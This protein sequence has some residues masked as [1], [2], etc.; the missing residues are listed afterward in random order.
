MQLLAAEDLSPPSLGQSADTLTLPLNQLAAAAKDRDTADTPHVCAD[1][2]SGDREPERKGPEGTARANGRVSLHCLQQ[3][4]AAELAGRSAID[5]CGPE[6]AAGACDPQVRTAGKGAVLSAGSL[7]GATAAGWEG[8][9]RAS[10]EASAGFHG[11]P[12]ASGAPRG[13]G[14]PP[15][16]ALNPRPSSPSPSPAAAAGAP[17]QRCAAA[18]SRLR[19][20]AGQVGP[21]LAVT[22]AGAPPNGGPAQEGFATGNPVLACVRMWLLHDL[23]ASK[24]YLRGSM[25]TQARISRMVL[26]PAFHKKLL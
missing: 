17:A 12:R 19:W 11:A 10:C 8:W 6:L 14:T 15:W 4:A 3:P 22:P 5:C 1:S 16:L 24:A 25:A 9:D 20:P 13:P 23:A 18:P 7:P 21:Q 26:S 2:T